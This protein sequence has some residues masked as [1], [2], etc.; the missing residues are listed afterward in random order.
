MSKAVCWASHPLQPFH[1]TNLKGDINCPICMAANLAIQPALSLLIEA[2]HTHNSLPFPVKKAKVTT[3]PRGAAMGTRS[4]SSAEKGKAPVTCPLTITSPLPHS[5]SFL[6]HTT[7]DQHTKTLGIL[8]SSPCDTSPHH[9]RLTSP[10][11]H[12][13][14]VHTHPHQQD[15]CKVLGFCTE[16][17][18]LQ[19]VRKV[20]PLPSRPREDL[21]HGSMQ[22]WN[23]MAQNP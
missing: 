6:S 20:N 14:L 3:T 18:I 21:R 7:P 16:P 5:L 1:N 22:L 12:I 15:S 4:Q 19:E 13:H 2:R 8:G 17:V 23:S 10:P 9:P 11:P